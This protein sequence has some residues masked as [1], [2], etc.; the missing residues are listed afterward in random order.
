MFYSANGEFKNDITVEKFTDVDSNNN[1]VNKKIEDLTNENNI[2]KDKINELY[3]ITKRL[4]MEK[5]DY[6]YLNSKV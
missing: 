2:L 3:K 1:D 4:E 5:A 6:F